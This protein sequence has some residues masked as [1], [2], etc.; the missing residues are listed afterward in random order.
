MTPRE[1]LRDA[2]A[3]HA[4]AERLLGQPRAHES[5]KEKATQASR[6]A[7]RAT[8][9]EARDLVTAAFMHGLRAG[10]GHSMMLS[11]RVLR[12]HVEGAIKVLA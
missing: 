5:A 10:L 9:D 4:S 3:L 7:I 1:A 12:H 8:L 2:D 11:L 6:A